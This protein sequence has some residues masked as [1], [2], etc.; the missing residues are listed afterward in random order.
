MKNDEKSVKFETGAKN[1]A[2]SDWSSLKIRKFGSIFK[3]EIWHEPVRNVL[4]QYF[5]GTLILSKIYRPI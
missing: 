5:L 4:F 1:P 2:V 3:K